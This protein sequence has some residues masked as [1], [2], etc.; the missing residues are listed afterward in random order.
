MEQPTRRLDSE[1]PD[2][3]PAAEGTDQCP[4]C[5][6]ERVWADVEVMVPTSLGMNKA[7][8]QFSREVGDSLLWGPQRNTTICVSLVCSACGFAEFYANKPDNLVV[9][10]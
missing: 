1:A 4:K 6:G 5:G 3:Q 10:E 2:Q 7:K 9:S 8:V